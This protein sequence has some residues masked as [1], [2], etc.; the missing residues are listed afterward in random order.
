[1]VRSI[2]YSSVSRSIPRDCTSCGWSM[3]SMAAAAFGD[4][5]LFMSIMSPWLYGGGGIVYSDIDTM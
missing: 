2:E 4:I 1:M 5:T 3:I